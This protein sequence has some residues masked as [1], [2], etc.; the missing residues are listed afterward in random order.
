MADKDI[1]SIIKDISEVI[2]D[3]NICSIKDNRFDTDS[4]VQL[5]ENLTHKKVNKSDSVYSA[6]YKGYMEGTPQ[7]VFGS[8]I[9]VSQAYSALEKIKIANR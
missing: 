9:T 2:S 7:I 1:S 8:F 4:M 3:W 6:V 5:T